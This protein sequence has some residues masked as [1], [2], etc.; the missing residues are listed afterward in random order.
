MRLKDKVAIV[1]GGAR[2]I[3]A[4]V[5]AAYAHEGARVVVN[6]LSNQDMAER[7]VARITASGG[8][9]VAVQGDVARAEDV[10][11]LVR[12]AHDHYG[13][14]D[15]MVAN[16][17]TYPR[18]PWHQIAEDEWDRVM[19]VNLKGALLCAQAVYPDMRARHYGKII[20]VSSV[21]VELGRGP[22]VH[23]VA[24]KAGLIGFTR[25]LAREVGKDG[26]LVNCVM[27]GAI[28]TEQELVEFPDQDELAAYLAER[29][30]LPERGLPE[31]M[32]GAFVYLAAAESDFVTGQV[33]NVDGGWVH[34]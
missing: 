12:T 31:D 22:Y 3:G 23:Y 25:A 16:A 27:P 19:D 15:I 30:C 18:T 29:Q 28:R 26:I 8:A 11:R 9:A 17:A 20:T 33:I 7:V 2:G 21:V 32:M 1:T 6:F 13:P 4:A 34:Y 14:V 10:Q 5:C 24:T